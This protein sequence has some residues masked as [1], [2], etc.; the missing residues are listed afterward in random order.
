MSLALAIERLAVGCYMP[1]SVA[2]DTRKAKDILDRIL[3][4]A[5]RELPECLRRALASEPASDTIAFINTLHFDVTINTEWPRDE[6]A[7]SLAI[8]LLRGLWRTLDDP[9]T[10]RFKDRAEML[11]RFFLDLAQGTAFTRSWHG[12]FA[13]LRLLLTSGIVRTSRSRRGLGTTAASG[14]AK[15][16]R[17][18]Q[19]AGCATGPGC[20]TQRCAERRGSGS[21]CRCDCDR[22]S[23]LSVVA[24]T[25]ATTFLRDCDG[26]A[27]GRGRGCG[28]A[29]ARA[30][31]RGACMETEWCDAVCGEIRCDLDC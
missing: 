6:I 3:S 9:D 26:A 23:R 12:C 4:S 19:R 20:N 1:K 8:Q 28:D 15:G 2:D 24:K 22:F 25:S 21:R 16:D 10:I 13:G 18:A 17:A 27:N 11:G 29:R 31:S 30:E 14:L 7:R 5:T